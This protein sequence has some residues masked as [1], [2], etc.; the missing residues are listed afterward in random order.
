MPLYF[1]AVVGHGPGDARI[2]APREHAGVD[3]GGALLGLAVLPGRVARRCARAA[4]AWTCRS[5]SASS[6]RSWR[7]CGT[8]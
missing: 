5:A 3:P 6:S 1:G 4:S 2:H 7:A 8:R